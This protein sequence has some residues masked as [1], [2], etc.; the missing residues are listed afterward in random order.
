M[1]R[2]RQPAA[3]SDDWVVNLPGGFK[4][5]IL[6]PVGKEVRRFSPLVTLIYNMDFA[7]VWGRK[8]IPVVFTGCLKRTTNL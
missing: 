1:F 2:G 4:S 7:A 5:P 8:E 3:H 6:I